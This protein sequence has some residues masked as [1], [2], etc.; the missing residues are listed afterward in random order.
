MVYFEV[1]NLIAPSRREREIDF[2][3]ISDNKKLKISNTL[4]KIIAGQVLRYHF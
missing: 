4:L 2:Q 1:K 3:S